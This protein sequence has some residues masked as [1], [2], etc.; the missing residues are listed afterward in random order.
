[1]KML[2]V[3]LRGLFGLFFICTVSNASA[4][5]LASWNDGDAKKAIVEFVRATTESGSKT[6]VPAGERVAT[7][8]QDGSMKNDWKKIFTFE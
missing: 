5:P 1:M 6:F 3:S 8:D 2:S 4:D 7:F